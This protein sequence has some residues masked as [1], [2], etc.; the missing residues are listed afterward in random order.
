MPYGYDIRQHTGETTRVHDT[1]GAYRLPPGLEPG[2][3]VVLE[4]FQP[5]YWTVRNCEGKRFLVSMTCVGDAGML[6]KPKRPPHPGCKPRVRASQ[7]PPALG[8]DDY[9]FTS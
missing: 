2:D 9:G 4:R 5:G 6:D 7:V 8:V 1:Q 3:E